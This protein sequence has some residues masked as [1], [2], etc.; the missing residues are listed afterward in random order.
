M[1]T[2]MA[3]GSQ[4]N[5]VSINKSFLIAIGMVHNILLLVVAIGA[6][7][8]GDGSHVQAAPPAPPAPPGAKN[9]L[10]VVVDDLRPQMGAY[11]QNQTLTPNIDALAAEALVF[12]RAYC[13]IAVCSP[14]RNSFMSGRRPDTT[15]V[16]NFKVDFRAP[17][18]YRVPS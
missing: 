12:D 8:S 3:A 2:F 18:V 13:Q 6:A 16:W 15:K 7:M 1:S 5:T 17:G 14:S 10:L 9:V 11:Y 4:H